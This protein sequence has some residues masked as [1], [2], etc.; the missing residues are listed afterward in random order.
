[1]FKKVFGKAK[2]QLKSDNKIIAKHNS[3]LNN[4][5]LKVESYA[6]ST[7]QD[8]NNI[9]D[10]ILN[11][12]VVHVSFNKFSE[13]DKRSY[14]AFI[15]GVVYANQSTYKKVGDDQYIFSPKDKA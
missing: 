6:P 10:A 11:Q 2:S 7:P 1:M 14:K 3:T 15:N 12:S 4:P 13:N 9:A 5:K 8:I